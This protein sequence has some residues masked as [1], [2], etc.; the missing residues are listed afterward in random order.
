MLDGQYRHGIFEVSHT[1]LEDQTRDLFETLPQLPGLTYHGITGNHDFTFTEACG[2]EVGHFITNY[3]RDRGRTDFKFYGN[4][5]AFLKIRGVLLHLWHPRSGVS[6]ARSYGIQKQIEKYS[7]IKPQIMLAG[8]WHVH[9]TVFERGIHALACP[10]F[11]GGGSAFSKSLGGAPAIGG[12]IL[13]WDLTTHGT[14]R[15]FGHQYRAYFEVE[16]PVIVENVLD[17]TPIKDKP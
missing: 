14:I 15:N 11:Q 13:S 16:K 7:S 6:Y 12:M 10:T 5:S 17:A 2:V 9:C 4:R 8:H 1:G 3:F